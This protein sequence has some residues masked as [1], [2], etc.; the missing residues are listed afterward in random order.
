MCMRS[1]QYN[2]KRRLLTLMANEVTTDIER[3]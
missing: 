3:S 1:C 2:T